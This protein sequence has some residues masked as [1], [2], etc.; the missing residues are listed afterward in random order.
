MRFVRRNRAARVLANM[1]EICSL[2]GS[3]WKASMCTDTSSSTAVISVPS[4]NGKSISSEASVA[5]SQPAVVSWSA[6]ATP[7]KPSF[8]ACSTSVR[9][10]SVPSEKTV[11]Q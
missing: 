11:W 10:V 8:L 6:I 3:Y 4:S 1:L 2:D 5:S 9:S 7:C